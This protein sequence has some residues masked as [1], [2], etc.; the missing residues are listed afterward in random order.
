MSRL[1]LG[2]HPDQLYALIVLESP[3][4]QLDPLFDFFVHEQTFKRQKILED[5]NCMAVN[6][7]YDKSLPIQDSFV[8][9]ITCLD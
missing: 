5:P 3:V 6:S 7:Y 8:L 4:R 1:W 2:P 9:K